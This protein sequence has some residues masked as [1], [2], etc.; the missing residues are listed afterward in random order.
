MHDH[1][2][3]VQYGDRFPSNETAAGNDRKTD[4]RLVGYFWYCGTEHMHVPLEKS[5]MSHCL[6][7]PK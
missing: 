3:T 6:E 4:A 5:Q 7:L 2:M 1:R